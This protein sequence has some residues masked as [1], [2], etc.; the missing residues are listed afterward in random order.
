[1]GNQ[2]VEYFSAKRHLARYYNELK[3]D[4]KK[5]IEI[6]EPICLQMDEFV[7]LYSLETLFAYSDL[8]YYYGKIND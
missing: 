6:I 4:Y 5:A 7:C 1:M 2:H 3:K 8:G